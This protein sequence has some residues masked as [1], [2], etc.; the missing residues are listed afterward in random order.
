MI[1]AIVLAAGKSSRMGAEN[2]MLLP[3]R[4]STIIGTV[5]NKLEQSL[6]DEIIIVENN[7]SNLKQQLGYGAKVKFV[8]NAAADL[9]LTTSIQCGIE[10]SSSSTDGYLICLGDMPLLTRND[11][12]SLINNLLANFTKVIIIPSFDNR[13][14]NPV[15]FSSDFKEEILLLQDKDGCKPVVVVND[16]YVVEIPLSTNNCHLDIDTTEEYQKFK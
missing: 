9:G 15:L 5:I 10:A 6:V 3:F 11:Y 1:S 12:N 8:T 2:K 16:K 14:G 13:R 4:G 7:K